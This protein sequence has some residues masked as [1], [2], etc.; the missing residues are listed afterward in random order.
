[1]IFYS[2]EKNMIYVIMQMTVHFIQLTSPFQYYHLDKNGKTT[3]N[4]VE[5]SQNT[6]CN[7]QNSFLLQWLA[8]VK[9]N[10]S[11]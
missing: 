10:F 6:L 4:E 11:C 5:Y 2:L 1:M 7:I 3:D 9:R 8:S